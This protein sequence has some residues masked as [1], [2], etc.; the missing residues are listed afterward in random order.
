MPQTH[1]ITAARCCCLLRFYSI[2]SG[3]SFRWGCTDQSFVGG[4]HP[5]RHWLEILGQFKS[6]SWWVVCGKS[7][8][9]TLRLTLAWR[10]A[11]RLLWID[12]I[13]VVVVVLQA[14]DLWYWHL[15]TE[16]GS[17]WQLLLVFKFLPCMHWLVNNNTL[18][19]KELMLTDCRYVWCT[20]RMWRNVWT[21]SCTALTETGSSLLENL[22]IGR[23]S[24]DLAQV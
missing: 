17:H 19:C 18:C 2:Q 23:E 12:E 22:S 15:Q 11:W 7:K 3:M 5:D 21:Q 16:G 6:V 9:I 24:Q 20:W 4:E 1:N 10:W 8:V 13:I 14:E